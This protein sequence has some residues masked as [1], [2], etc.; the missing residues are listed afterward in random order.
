VLH[1]KFDGN[2][3]DSSGRGNDGYPSNSPSIVPGNIGSGALSYA[4]V[5]IVDTNTSTTNFSSSLWISGSARSDFALP[6]IS[7]S[8]SG[9]VHRYAG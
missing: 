9:E 1:L 5:A 3:L 4:T 8:H 7:Q 6:R 2:Y